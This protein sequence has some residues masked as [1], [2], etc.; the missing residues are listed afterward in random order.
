MHLLI[1]LK[2]QD[3]IHIVEQI[4]SVISAQIPDLNIHP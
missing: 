1:F 4:N 3:K 2:E